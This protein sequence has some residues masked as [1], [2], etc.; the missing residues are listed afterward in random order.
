V[1]E[2]FE[3]TE[4]TRKAR[5]KAER[6]AAIRQAVKD[7]LAL[8]EAEI[9]QTE[10]ALKRY[11]LAFESGS[12]PASSLAARIHQL[13]ERHTEVA[14]RRQELRDAMTL[15]AATQCAPDLAHAWTNC[16]E[17]SMKAFLALACQPILVG[18]T[19]RIT[20]L[21]ETCV[22]G[23]GPSPALDHAAAYGGRGAWR[24]ASGLRTR[25]LTSTKSSRADDGEA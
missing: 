12:L 1:V 17:A 2:S 15:P 9:R 11:V 6:Q 20:L 7:Q 19:I 10:E 4:V 16:R 23:L 5:E 24:A 21:S 22:R 8:V 14:A 18:Q 13:N 25:N 3:G